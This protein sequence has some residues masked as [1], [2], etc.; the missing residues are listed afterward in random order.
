MTPDRLDVALFRGE[1]AAELIPIGMIEPWPDQPRRSI[2]DAQLLELAESIG[3]VGVLQPILVRPI[4]DG[5]VFGIV[6]GERRFRA[7]R[8]AGLT[9]I[10]AVVRTLTD[11]E[12]LDVALT[13]N[14]QRVDV[15]PLD[16]A[17]GYERLHQVHQYTIDE[18]A[19]KVGKSRT[20]VYARLKLTS[21][22]D[23]ARAYLRD[24]RLTPTVAL[25]VARIPTPS[26]QVEA[27][28]YCAADNRGQALN[29]TAAADYIRST[30]MLRLVA[31]EFDP[32]D[33]TLVRAAGPC[34][35]CPKR[36]GAHPELFGD[37]PD[38]DTCTDGGCYEGKTAAHHERHASTLEMAG[39]RVIRGAK[40]KAL[41]ANGGFG[42]TAD[43]QDTYVLLTDRCQLDHGRRAWREVLFGGVEI[44]RVPPSR[45]VL[46]ERPRGGWL[47]AT[48]RAVAMEMLRELGIGE[49]PAEPTPTGATEPAAAAPTPATKPAWPFPT[50]GDD[51]V[52]STLQKQAATPAPDHIVD[53][54][55]MVDAPGGLPPVS[56]LIDPLDPGDRSAR[57]RRAYMAAL[58]R[59]VHDIDGDGGREWY[60]YVDTT[61]LRGLCW[62][63]CDLIDM[64][65]VLEILDPDGTLTQPGAS[66]RDIRD[67]L[68]A[69]WEGRDDLHRLLWTLLLGMVAGD[70]W[71]ASRPQ[72][73]GILEHMARHAGHDPAGILGD[74]L[75][76]P[77]QEREIEKPETPAAAAPAKRKRAPR[78]VK[79]ES[80]AAPAADMDESAGG[81][82]EA[83]HA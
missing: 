63:L 56:T 77:T 14:L 54:D 13:E 37:V 50:T 11:A 81:A 29:A 20:Y 26:Q 48:V 55:K 27:A 22:C 5:A 3:K 9:H 75:A 42:L 28:K 51:V 80:A 4:R 40:A 25:L 67:V 7:A 39:A 70:G 73:A 1:P 60:E 59:A 61:T 43:A 44:E 12:A 45:L 8:R 36:T 83:A 38:A 65:P 49:A 16:E 82:T 10:P 78:K 64:T 79:S 32:A 35:A 74:L 66:D 15:P 18:I 41:L 47:H 72:S 33:A 71:A 76:T 19:D 68:L 21:L 2:D 58:A 17:E 69:H 53:V 30:Y 23:D 62:S 57:S 46:I 52:V 24:G 31:A 6:S 34:T